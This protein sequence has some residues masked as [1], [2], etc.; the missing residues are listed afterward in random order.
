MDPQVQFSLDPQVRSQSLH[1]QCNALKKEIIAVRSQRNELQ[2]QVVFLGREV[3]EMKGT[4][5]IMEQERETTIRK[6]DEISL[7]LIRCETGV[8][9]QEE[10]LLR[11]HISGKLF[12]SHFHINRMQKWGMPWNKL[13]HSKDLVGGVAV[14][15]DPHKLP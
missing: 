1:D 8:S 6:L 5:T 12:N 4:L 7:R 10:G 11:D 13:T 3:K 2:E 14:F 9:Q 15:C